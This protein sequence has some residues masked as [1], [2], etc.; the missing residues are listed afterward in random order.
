V[1]WRIP[2]P[3]RTPRREWAHRWR[4]VEAVVLVTLAAGAQ[5]WIPMP[6]WSK[7]LG[8]PVAVPDSWRGRSIEILPTRW[9][10]PEEL[11]AARAVR[12]AARVVPWTPRCL[13]EAT[14]GQVL[15]RRAGHPGVVVI[16]LKPTD[17]G[18]WDAHAW[19]LGAHGAL[20]GGRAAAGFTATTAFEVPGGQ[21]AAEI[22]LE[23]RAT[24]SPSAGT[25]TAT[26][27]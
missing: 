9:A 22:D 26:R 5:R 25:D 24:P 20:T 19:L 2:T 11:G 17:S 14:A 13:A 10:S 6:R 3:W 7:I 18:S 12:G 16:G 15:L 21:L 1:H 8:T 27:H 23:E 4:V